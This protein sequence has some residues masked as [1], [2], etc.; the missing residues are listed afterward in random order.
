MKIFTS[1][2]IGLV[3][4]ISSAAAQD[5]SPQLEG[6]W[7]ASE[8]SVILADGTVKTVPG[9]YE[10]LQVVISDQQDTVFKAVQTVKSKSGLATGT[11]GGA[12]LTG[13]PT[14]MIGAVSGTGPSVVFV[15]I[16]DTTTI[17]CSLISDDAMRCLI[18][19]PG[20][21]AVAG[22]YLLKRQ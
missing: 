22:T 17:A 2:A 20:E 1:L 19:E 9:D 8:G 16:G 12:P 3:A 14:D 15:D 7:V 6:T 11:H 4:T 5:F 10:T 21:D 13:Q 18:A